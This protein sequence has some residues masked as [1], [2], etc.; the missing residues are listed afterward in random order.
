MRE[1]LQGGAPLEL[2][3]HPQGR[4]GFDILD[5]FA[6]SREIIART[7]DFLKTHLREAGSIT[8]PPDPPHE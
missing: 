8:R 6:R 2:L 5:D 1:G 4:H 7:F 3:N